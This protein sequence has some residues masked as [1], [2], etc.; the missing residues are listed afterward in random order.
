M[1][2]AASWGVVVAVAVVVVGV[3]EAAGGAELKAEGRSGC[4]V[5]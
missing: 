5:W 1:P 3:A 4:C 2:E